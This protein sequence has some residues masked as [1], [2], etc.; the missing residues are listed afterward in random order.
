MILINN[1]WLINQQCISVQ[2]CRLAG[3]IYLPLFLQ[4]ADYSDRSLIYSQGWPG[5]PGCSPSVIDSA[6]DMKPGEVMGSEV[7]FPH[8]LSHQSLQL[9]FW[10]PQ[11]SFLPL[12]A[13]NKSWSFQISCISSELFT[14]LHRGLRFQSFTGCGITREYRMAAVLGNRSWCVLLPA[15][16]LLPVVCAENRYPN[17]L[18]LTWW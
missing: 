2:G 9:G 11:V 1:Y 12:L 10:Q 3:L 6:A 15:T 7:Q 18:C 5:Q 8:P 14:N 4:R 16:S 17:T 13:S